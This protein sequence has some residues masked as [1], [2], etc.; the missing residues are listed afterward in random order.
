[1]LGKLDGTVAGSAV[2][3]SAND[4]M[5]HGSSSQYVIFRSKTKRP[6][7]SPRKAKAEAAKAAALKAEEES[8]EKDLAC[9]PDPRRAENGFVDAPLLGVDLAAEDEKRTLMSKNFGGLNADE[10][11][12]Q[13]AI[14][15]GS[16]ITPNIILTAAHC[17]KKY[18]THVDIYDTQALQPITYKIYK[19][20]QHPKYKRGEF[21]H[22]VG[23]IVIKSTHL[24]VEIVKGDEN[25]YY[26]NL[27]S[28]ELYNWEDAPPM[29]RL[30]HYSS[31][32]G[33]DNDIKTDTA[34]KSSS[35]SCNTLTNQQSESITTLTV[36]GYG[37]TKFTNSNGPTNP[38]YY[39]L[40]GADVHYI[41]NDECNALY[42]RSSMGNGVITNDMMCASDFKQQQDAC[43]GDS[44]G[45]LVARLVEDDSNNGLWSQMGVVSWGI[46]CA[47]SGYPGVY[48]RVG[49]EID[50]IESTICGRGKE[51][52]LSPFSCVTSIDNGKKQL[53]DYAL[54]ATAIIAD[55]DTDS[56]KKKRRRASV[57][58]SVG[59]RR[60]KIELTLQYNK[61]E[62]E[63]SSKTKQS[64]MEACELLEGPF[65]PTL[66]PVSMT[67]QPTQSPTKSPLSVSKNDDSPTPTTTETTG[68]AEKQCSSNNSK[69]DVKYFTMLNK[70]TRR[71]SCK[72]VRRKCH[73]RC[74]D[75]SDCCPVTCGL[76]NCKK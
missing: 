32:S 1:M 21:Q 40:Q 45:P 67:E 14:C 62:V 55:N 31:N 52:G 18:E 20:V 66:S 63:E 2:G 74:G 42:E 6:F 65:V 8:A 10:S 24:D 58:S 43:S 23:L 33:S 35:S 56:T 30:H 15:G 3:G 76:P 60:D 57:E 22:D 51:V 71:R 34:T 29:I 25:E 12:I 37:A 64:R 61:E 50:W 27:K 5:L 28:I 19:S 39:S 4:N 17:L 75:Y 48:S 13:S 7:Y 49:E 46:G 72:W 69:K 54:E 59:N 11:K 36:L 53:R 70:S 73:H 16:L 9:F 26:W 44:G 47:L 68:T 41:T 38:S